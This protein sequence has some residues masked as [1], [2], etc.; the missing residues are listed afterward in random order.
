MYMKTL[1]LQTHCTVYHVWKN[2]IWL[3][4]SINC[5][6]SNFSLSPQLLQLISKGRE[7]E[8]YIPDQHKIRGGVLLLVAD[9]HFELRAAGKFSR[10]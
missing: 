2:F 1:H 10:Y 5:S 9:T 7:G 8:D 4:A 6:E 3:Y